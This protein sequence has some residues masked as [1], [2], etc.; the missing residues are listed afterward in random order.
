VRADAENR[1]GKFAMD[2]HRAMLGSN[3]IA[4]GGTPN[5]AKGKRNVHTIQATKGLEWE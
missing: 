1:V 3:R 2:T 4:D 5:V